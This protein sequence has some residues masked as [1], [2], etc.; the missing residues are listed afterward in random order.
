VTPGA[1]ASYTVNVTPSGGFSGSVALS[2]T[3][4]PAGATGTLNPT[5][6]TSSSTLNVTTTTGVTPA[7][8]YPLTITGVS[9]GLTRTSSATLVVNATATPDFSLSVS[10]VSQT[11][12]QATGT[13]YTVAINPIS[14][15][16]GSVALSL[17]GLPAGASGSFSAVVANSSTLT[18]T[19][20]S[21]MPV[22]IYPLTITGVSGALTRT[23]SA[24]LVV[25]TTI[26]STDL[27][28]ATCT[29]VSAALPAAVTDVTALAADGN[30]SLYV[31]SPG[32]FVHTL[33]SGGNW[34]AAA[35]GPKNVSSFFFDTAVAVKV[36]AAGQGTGTGGIW[37]GPISTVAANV[38][39]TWTSV[40]AAGAT[41]V[42]NN[43][44]VTGFSGLASSS[45]FLFAGTP[46]TAGQ[47]YANLFRYTG[48]NWGASADGI[49]GA[50]VAALTLTNAT[51]AAIGSTVV[52]A[53]TSGGG[54]FKTTT[55]GQ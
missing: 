23:V 4:L 42:T 24:T 47:Q 13:T 15:F 31:G 39:V 34:T 19:S 38:T 35:T 33:A 51:N 17:S 40:P 11:V 21:A 45:P 43:S 49:L 46:F 14:S 6:T 2:V 50:N 1:P 3:G 55:G 26:W 28:A 20:T 8:S 52:L 22:G 27:T 7:G 10:P 37:N 41:S 29:P 53:G 44:T 36:Y 25:S 9:G 16:N 18:V 30:G 5:S 54:I 12:T 48:T 32:N